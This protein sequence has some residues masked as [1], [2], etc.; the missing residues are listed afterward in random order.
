MRFFTLS[1][2]NAVPV[3]ASKT[4]L[5]AFPVAEVKVMVFVSL[6]PVI[7]SQIKISLLTPEF[8]RNFT[9]PLIPQIRKSINASAKLKKSLPLPPTV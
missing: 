1:N 5:P 3:V 2:V 6:N 9:L 4:T 7:E 8:N